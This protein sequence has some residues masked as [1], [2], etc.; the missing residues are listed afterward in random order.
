[1][2]ASLVAHTIHIPEFLATWRVHQDQGTNMGFLDSAEHRTLLIEMIDHALKAAKS[3]MPNHFPHFHRKKLKHLLLK[4]KLHIEIK[5]QKNK[6]NRYKIAVKWLFTNPG[7]LR[8]YRT[9]KKSKK[10]YFSPLEPL[11]F[12]R[13]IIAEYGL[14]KNVK[15]TKNYC[16]NPFLY[17]VITPKGDV[18][19]C[20]DSWLPKPI[21]NIFNE[22]DFEKIWNSETAQAIRLTMLNETYEFCN[23]EYCPFLL[24]GHFKPV[25]I[26]LGTSA[27]NKEEREKIYLLNG[28]RRLA[29]SYDPTCNLHCKSC[30][31]L[32]TTLNKEKTD[33]MLKFQENLLNS[34][35]FSNIRELILSGTG[36]P[37]AGKV[38]LSLLQSINERRFP[39]LRITLMTNG[40]LFTPQNWE[41]ISNSH[42]AIHHIKISIDAATKETYE[43]LRRGANFDI[44]LDNLKFISRLKRQKEFKLQAVFVMQKENYRE[45]PGFVE[46]MKKYDFDYISFVKLNNWGT[47]TKEEFR[48]AAIHRQEH[49]EH[50]I[51]LE[52]L[53]N[54]VL[55]DRKVFIDPVTAGEKNIDKKKVGIEI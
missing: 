1:M 7:I 37:F 51:F 36:D 46:L 55:N 35:F 18:F 15:I 44:L 3:F 17:V 21:G 39:Y 48:Q 50:E 25:K 42:Y 31:N 26:N 33:S 24:R 5:E 27:E 6:V 45:M 14:D 23:R 41:K 16:R 34:P 13:K 10:S 19:T 47:Y 12:S 20:C 22:P 8:D 11:E 53:K 4:E 43:K 32:V 54:P 38:C 2:R 49:P 9:S 30:R 52:T 28:P 29:V 40:I